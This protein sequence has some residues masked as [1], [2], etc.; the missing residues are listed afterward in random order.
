M[1]YLDPKKKQ[2]HKQRLL[3]GYA[4]TGVLIAMLT[5]L[6]LF[7]ANGYFIDRNTGQ[8]IQN[9]LVFI[10]AR[11]APARITL[12]GEL[13]RGQ[14]DARL[15]IPAGRYTIDLAREGY[16]P[17]S[18]TIDLEGGSLRRLTYARLIPNEL[19]STVSVALP[20]NPAHVSQSIDKKWLLV[21]YASNAQTLTLINVDVATPTAQELVLPPEI[22][23]PVEGAIFEVVEWADDNAHALISYGLKDQPKQYILID[24]QNPALTQNL[25]ALFAIPNAEIHLQDRKKDRF[26]VFNPATNLLATATLSGGVSTTPFIDV[27]LLA[28]RTFVS[29]WA[30]YV[31]PSETEGSVDARLRRG[32]QDILLKTIKQDSSY[33]LELAKLGSVPVIAIASPTENPITVFYDPEKYLAE[34]KDATKAVAA[35]IIRVQG[36]IDVSISSD[37]STVMAYGTERFASYEFEDEIAYSYDLDVSV[38]ATQQARWMDGQHFSFS[39]NGVQHMVDFD[40]SNLYD[41]VPSMPSVGSF[42]ANDILTMFTF[43]EATV[44]SETAPATPARL[45]TTRLITPEDE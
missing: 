12:N 22:V 3:I 10:D 26:F 30:V 7:V 35:T 20:A 21:S 40:G 18:R 36:L 34:N 15:V 37:A 44:A 38:D 24:R 27:P 5:I 33:I 32:N 9:G 25:T 13:Q 11:P 28:Y 23:T 16:R 45:I 29:D 41:L 43:S 31:I 2:A 17:W 1:D 8:I 42:Y 19:T 14:T 6:F 4:L 39:S